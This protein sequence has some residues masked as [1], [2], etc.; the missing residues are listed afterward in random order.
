[1]SSDFIS[2]LKDEV[3]CALSRS[4]ISL[5]LK[6]K[7]RRFELCEN[8]DDCKES[9][10]YKSDLSEMYLFFLS[11]SFNI[12]FNDLLT[13]TFISLIGM[14]SYDLINSLRDTIRVESSRFCFVT[15]TDL[16]DFFDVI[17]LEAFFERSISSKLSVGDFLDSL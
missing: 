6:N 9:Q 2:F 4:I 1:M 13:H 14:L 17:R 16:I 3:S 12:F 7:Q 15:L 10:I 11:I 5:D 8:R